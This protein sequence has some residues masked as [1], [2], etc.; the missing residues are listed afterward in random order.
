MGQPQQG[1]FSE[2]ATAFHFLEYTVAGGDIAALRHAL[3]ELLVDPPGVELVV[4]FGPDLLRRLAPEIAPAGFAGL[5]PL[6][7][8]EFQMPATQRD[9]LVWVKGAALD[10][11]FERVLQVQRTLGPLAELCLDIRGFQYKDSRDLIG[12]VD[13][14]ANPKG[15]ARQLAA[16]V[17]ADSPGAG[18]SFVLSQQWVHK[19]ETFNA[20]PVPEQERVV[21]RTKLDSIELEGEA[22][23]ADSHVSRTDVEVEGVAQKVWR[24]SAPYGDAGV[25]GLYYLAFACE[26]QRFQVQLERMYGLSDDGLHDRIIEFSDAVT[27]SYWFAPCQEDLEALAGDVFTGT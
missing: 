21:G 14:S 5:A 15:D 25:H 3:H 13:G 23:P 26:Q 27:G 22:M 17:P 2:G 10:A 12:F 16:C 18:G 9:M 4:A 8:G 11:V 7:G 20:L 19:L 6:D 24:R 1:I